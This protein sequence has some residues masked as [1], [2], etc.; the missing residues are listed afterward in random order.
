MNTNV[1][2]YYSIWSVTINF[3]SGLKET[4]QKAKQLLISY[5]AI[6]IERQK[7]KTWSW[8]KSSKYALLIYHFTI[9]IWYDRLTW[10][11]KSTCVVI[12]LLVDRKQFQGKEAMTA[13]AEMANRCTTSS[14]SVPDTW[15]HAQHN[16]KFQ[17]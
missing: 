15:A 16:I 12:K 13:K 8:F 10:Q 14:S 9:N 11:L 6:H 5:S 4:I 7:V 2:A 17:F 3:W 1:F